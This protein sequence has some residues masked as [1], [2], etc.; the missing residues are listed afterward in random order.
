[1]NE[2]EKAYRAF[3]DAVGIAPNDH[4]AD[5]PRRVAAFFKEYTTGFSK[6]PPF[7]FTCF[8]KE[9]EHTYDQLI[10]ERNIVFHS[11]CAHHHLPFYGVCALGYL[12]SD[13]IVGLSKLV[14]LVQWKATKPSIQE[15]LTEEIVRELE[16]RLEPKAAFVAMNATHLC[17]GCRGAR[18]S[19]AETITHAVRGELGL[20]LKDEFLQL[21][22]IV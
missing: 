3:M 6:E 19:S 8:P 2:A 4:N 7:N 20:K 14:R 18:S 13:Q 12:P 9:K 10:V 16:T 11:M 1:M 17:V 21:S 15:D 22:G 5:T